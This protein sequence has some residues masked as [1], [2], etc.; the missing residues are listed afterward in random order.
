MKKAVMFPYHHDIEVVIDNKDYLLDYELLGIIS[1]KEDIDAVMKLNSMLGISDEASYNN[2]IQNCDAL[3]ILDNYRQCKTDKYYRI[4]DEAIALNKEVVITPQAALELN[5]EKYDGKYRIL[6]NLSECDFSHIA[7]K[8]VNKLYDI[9]IPV[10]G[11]VGQGSYCD[12]FRTHMILKNVMEKNYNILS[13]SSN[14]LGA[15]FGCYTIPDF[16]FANEDFE[17]KIFKFNYF[18]RYLTER[19][20]YDAILLSIPEGIMPFERQVYHHFGEYPLIMGTA[21]SIDT[22]VLCPYLIIGE[23]L[24]NGLK[25]IMQFCANKFN[26][27]V[28]LIAVSHVAFEVPYEIGEEI[29]FEYFKKDMLERYYPHINNL[30]MLNITNLKSA[31]DTINSFLSILQENIEII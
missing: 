17:T 11:I 19:N 31:E 8:L 27:P 20:S 6:Q 29:I 28:G 9:D 21:I 3:I 30:P 5:L 23:Q 14:S 7:H 25:Q 1:Y 13:I 12:K 18:V 10:I 26:I 4:I 2:L 24:E 15:L 22:A 16:I